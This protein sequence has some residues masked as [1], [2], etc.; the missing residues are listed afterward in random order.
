MSRQLT[1]NEAL[2]SQVTL[3]SAE[4]MRSTGEAQ[5]RALAHLIRLEQQLTGILAQSS[6]ANYRKLLKQ[7]RDTIKANVSAAEAEA[8]RQQSALIVSEAQATAQA[9][10]IAVGGPLATA[11]SSEAFVTA[12]NRRAVVMGAPAE[13]W[14]RRQSRRTFERFSDITRQGVLLGRTNQ[15]M[16][17]DWSMASRQLRRHAEAQVRTSVQSTTNMARLETLKRNS[18]VIKAVQA[19]ATL[20]LRTSETCRD[21]D[22]MSWPLDSPSFPGPPPWHWNC[23]TTL[24]PVLKEYDALKPSDKLKVPAATRASMNGQVPRS[25]TYWEWFRTLDDGDQIKV[26]GRKEWEKWR[27]K[28]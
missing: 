21:R 12:V 25:M 4:V 28:Q 20:D 24:V 17:S 13:E 8:L 15:E 2:A 19:V 10:N 9:I 23:R 7:A 14:W 1:L 5:Q 22:G 6:R 3:R 18:D 11:P 16:I 27:A 26:L